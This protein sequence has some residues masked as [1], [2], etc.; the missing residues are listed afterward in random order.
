MSQNKNT[1]TKYEKK[2]NNNLKMGFTSDIHRHIKTERV[3]TKRVDKIHN[4]TS[5]NFLDWIKQ[6]SHNVTVTNI[7][8]LLDMIS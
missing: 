3:H 1:M 8:V 5:S 2:K 4:I 7:I 6:N